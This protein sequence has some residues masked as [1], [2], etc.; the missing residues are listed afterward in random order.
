MFSAVRIACTCTI[1]PPLLALANG[2]ADPAV[3]GGIADPIVVR[4]RCG[5][6]CATAG[7]AGAAAI[8]VAAAVN[9][10]PSAL[11]ML[12]EPSRNAEAC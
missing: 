12:Q 4:A 10:N 2:I 11:V 8:A 3:V 9:P 1:N 5:S 6:G 7:A